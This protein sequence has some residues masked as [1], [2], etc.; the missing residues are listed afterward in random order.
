MQNPKNE[1]NEIQALATFVHGALAS[2]HA[3]GFVYN[4]ARGNRKDAIIHAAA[5]TYD[6]MCTVKH[7][8]AIQGGNYEG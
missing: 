4:T 8:K 7:F 5:F 1:T 6:C 2:M 3:L